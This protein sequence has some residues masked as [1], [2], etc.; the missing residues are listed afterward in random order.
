MAAAKQRI[1]NLQQHLKSKAIDAIIVE[2]PINLFYLTEQELSTGCLLVTQKSARLFV[3]SRYY[4]A[5]KQNCALPVTL[6]KEGAIEKALASK[7]FEDVK[8][9]GFDSEATTYNRML[10][11]RSLLRKSAKDKVKLHPMKSPIKAL[12]AIKSRDEIAALKRAA[13]LGSEGYDFVCGILKGG[14]TESEVATELEIFWKRKGGKGLAFDSIIAFGANSSMPHYK[15][16]NVK[17]KKGDPILIDIGVNVNHYHS[18]MTRVPFFGKPSKKLE[19]IYAIVL[20]A[21]EEALKLCMPGTKISALDAAARGI[22]A[23]HGY[24]KNFSHSLGHGIGLEVHEL[25]FIRGTNDAILEAGMVL[26]IEPGIY[27]ERVG[28]VRI[29]DTV[30]I[31]E[32]GHDNLTARPKEPLIVG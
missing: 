11:L 23:E 27:L 14:I 16:G 13:K 9:L 20:E 22:I 26:T 31:T 15:P 5:C 21:Q 7:H 2:E 32:N 28:G 19:E 18:D 4:E 30:V 1:K 12:R 25:P 24:A 8:T 6:L 3:D 10:Q 29:E 17:L